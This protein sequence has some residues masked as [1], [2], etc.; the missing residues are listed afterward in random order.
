MAAQPEILSAL[1]VGF[2]YAQP[3][4]VFSSSEPH[5]ILHVPKAA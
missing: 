3:V 1:S 2:T 4:A 5:S